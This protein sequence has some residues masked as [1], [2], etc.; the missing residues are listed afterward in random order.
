MQK[1]VKQVQGKIMPK[2]CALIEVD[3]DYLKRTI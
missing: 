1:L 3:V 2:V